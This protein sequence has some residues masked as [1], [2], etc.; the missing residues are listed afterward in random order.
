MHGND[1]TEDQSQKIKYIAIR[2]F[3][4]YV[5]RYIILR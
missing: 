2:F 4:L 3:T 5:K 1:I